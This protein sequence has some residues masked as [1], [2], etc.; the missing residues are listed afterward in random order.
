MLLRKT[1]AVISLLCTILLIDHAIFHA[2]WM[3]SG[4]SI[5][6][7]AIPSWILLWS[8]AAHAIISIVLAIRGH[9][10]AEKRKCNGYP[11]MNVPTYMQRASGMALIVFTA[12][13]VL[14]TVGVL[15]PPQIVHVILPPLFFAFALAHAA[16]SASKALITLGIGNVKVIKI[17]NIVVR[18]LCVMTWIADVISFYLYAV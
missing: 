2:A 11:K 5:P 10:G 6:K 1:N 13:H 8:M 3:F 7:S 16:I 17:T 15:Q 9:K 18:M 4:C 14:G 12:L